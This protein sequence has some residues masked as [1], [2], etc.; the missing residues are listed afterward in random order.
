G[1]DVLDA[2]RSRVA[3]V[4]GPQLFAGCPVVRAKEN[5]AVRRGQSARI[6]ARAAGVDVLDAIGARVGA[7]AGPKLRATA[8]VT[9][10]VQPVPDGT[11]FIRIGD[12]VR[13]LHRPRLRPVRPPQP[14]LR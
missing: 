12:T 2:I 14:A 8:V 6:A 11:E 9:A 3:A 1:V 5:P 10:E 4:A 13:H 7:V